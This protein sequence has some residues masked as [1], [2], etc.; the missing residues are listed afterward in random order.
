MVNGAAGYFGIQAEPDPEPK[1]ALFTRSDQ[2]SFVLAG[3]PSLHIKYG[4]K[5]ADGGNNLNDLVGSM[6]G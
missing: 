6:E 4:N 3:I 1:Q 5:T 2:Y